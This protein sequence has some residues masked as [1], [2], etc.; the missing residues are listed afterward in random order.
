MKN[1]IDNIREFREW[2]LA[3]PPGHKGFRANGFSRCPLAEF[4]ETFVL[5]RTYF[6]PTAEFD[7]SGYPKV[8]HNL[9]EWARIFMESMYEFADNWSETITVAHVLAYIDRQIANEGAR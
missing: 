4:S 5:T 2:L 9:P 6:D 8:V 7:D 1:R 3:L